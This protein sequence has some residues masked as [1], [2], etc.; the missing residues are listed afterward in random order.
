[1][2][3]KLYFYDVPDEV[4]FKKSG[5]NLGLTHNHVCDDSKQSEV[6]LHLP[7]LRDLSGSVLQEGPE[8]RGDS[9]ENRLPLFLVP[10]P[11]RQLKTPILK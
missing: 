1:M 3:E 2:V 6:S 8:I 10:R 9:L 5:L 11:D 4:Q 7:L